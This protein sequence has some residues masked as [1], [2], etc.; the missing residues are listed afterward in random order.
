MS[1]DETMSDLHQPWQSE[2]RDVVEVVRCKDCV[3]YHESTIGL[4]KCPYIRRGVEEDRF[5][6]WG[7][8]NE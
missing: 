3:N 4:G 1:I 2:R 8:R 6:S 5:C 7:R